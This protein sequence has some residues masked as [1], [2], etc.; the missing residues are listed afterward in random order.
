M[1]SCAKPLAADWKR[2]IDAD[3]QRRESKTYGA[4]IG[5]IADSTFEFRRK[6]TR[7]SPFFITGIDITD[8]TIMTIAAARAL[9]QWREEGG[10]LHKLMRWNMRTLGRNYPYPLGAYGSSFSVCLRSSRTEPDNRCGNGS[11][12]R[13]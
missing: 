4:I 9:M 13:V 2:K 3:F 12:M 1:H 10:N 6:K 8:D 7:D 11:A 5:N